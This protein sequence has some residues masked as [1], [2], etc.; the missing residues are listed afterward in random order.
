MKALIATVALASSL[1]GCAGQMTERASR[2]R[3]AE[4][5]AVKECQFLGQVTGTSTLTGIARHSGY[6][7]ALNELLDEAAERGASHVMLSRD[8]RPA[9]WTFAQNVRGEAYRCKQ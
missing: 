6:Q 2:V 7:N 5:E 3:M 4:A 8:S 9:Y 1:T